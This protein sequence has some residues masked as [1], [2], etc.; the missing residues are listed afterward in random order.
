M[1]KHLLLIGLLISSFAVQAQSG[2]LDKK[3]EK[4]NN[5]VDK[6]KYSDAD[7]A[8]EKILDENPEYGDGWD[9][10]ARIRY[11]EYKDS[12]NADGL[13]GGNF[14]ITTTDK[15]G[16]KTDGNDSLSKQL[17]ELLTSIKPSKV[18][19]NKYKYTLRLANIK[20]D[21][22]YNNSSLLRIYFVDKPVDTAVGKKALKYFNN[23]EEEFSKKNYAE[24][25]KLYKR[26]IDEQPDFYKAALYMGDCFYFLKNYADAITSFKVAIDRFPTQL[27]PRKYLVDAY[28][29]EKLYAKAL[30]ECIAAMK[31]YP[32]RTIMNKMD[33]AAYL[34][35]K[36]LDIKCTPRAVFP[37]STTAADQDRNAYKPKEELKATGAWG[38]YQDEIGRMKNN[39]DEKGIIVNPNSLTQ[40]RYLEVYSW[41]EM[42]KNSTDPT[43][44]EAR[45]MQKDGY[46]DCYV[47][48]T[49]FHFD[50]YDQYLDF[51]AKNASRITD[52]F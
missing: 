21:D 5:L 32:D 7:E 18:A 37:N 47:M 8:L 40:S 38:Y 15:D 2:K 27:E 31:V 14:T 11:Q 13:M 51:V 30:D 43:L 36:K 10:L 28:A 29:K 4:V 42:L 39:C 17:M 33:D 19:Y 22:S 34:N 16:K 48:I 35:N 45:R 49:C 9:Y 52:Y 6:G 26:A 23:A 1:N 12:K 46:L 25:A 50:F 24:A 44:D 3:I 41:E 20:T